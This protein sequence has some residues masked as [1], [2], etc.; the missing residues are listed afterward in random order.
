M[1]R[2]QSIPRAA[3]ATLR[4][5]DV[6][7]PLTDVA[8]ARPDEPVVDLIGRLTPATGRRA[9]VLDGGLLVGIVTAR[10]LDR[11]VEVSAVAS[12]RTGG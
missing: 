6:L 7:T 9:L 8:V 5:D 10:D 4:V 2:L 1:S 3:R 12:A 11:A